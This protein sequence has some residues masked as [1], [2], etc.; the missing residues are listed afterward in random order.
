MNNIIGVTRRALGIIA[1]YEKDSMGGTRWSAKD[2]D[3]ICE[4]SKDFP[5]KVDEFHNVRGEVRQLARHAFQDLI[6]D[7]DDRTAELRKYCYLIQDFIRDREHVPQDPWTKVF[8]EKR[9]V[10]SPP[11]IS[12]KGAAAR[13]SESKADAQ[14]SDTDQIPHRTDS[15]H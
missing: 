3:M 11:G 7:L 9:G 8:A 5:S 6:K 14:F 2:I 4:T 10:D 13:E 1:N 12:I 15:S